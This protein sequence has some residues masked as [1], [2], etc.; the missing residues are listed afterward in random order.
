MRPWDL[1]PGS[2]DTAAAVEALAGARGRGRSASAGSVHSLVVTEEGALYSFGRGIF[3]VLGHGSVGDERSPM[4]VDALCHV[5]IADAAAGVNFSLALTEDGTVFSWGRNTGG[6]LGP[7]HKGGDEALPQKVEALSGLKV[8][9]VAA[10][11]DIS[12]AV[13]AAGALYMWGGG[14]DGRLGRG[15]TADQL[16]PKRVEALRDEWVVAAAVGDMHAIAVT[17][18]GIVFGWGAADR[19]GLP[20]A[21]AVVHE[22]HDGDGA[23]TIMLPC[24][25]PQLT[26]GHPTLS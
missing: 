20:E 17:R 14:E 19:L 13:T 16:A 8:C 5:R 24:H 25:Y 21:A 4:M 26:I 9:A 7:G 12:S 22:D 2:A 18:D 15:D 1:R 11:C 23:T 3:G 6:Q 10:G